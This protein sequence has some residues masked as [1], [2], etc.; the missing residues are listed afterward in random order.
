MLVKLDRLL[1]ALLLLMVILLVF[2]FLER[3]IF[4]PIIRFGQLSS[5]LLGPTLEA[6]SFHW[7]LWL[8]LRWLIRCACGCTSI[9]HIIRLVRLGVLGR[10]LLTLSPHINH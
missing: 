8:W 7:L 10:I 3:R 2:L 1:A 4:W 5:Q 9:V 6:I